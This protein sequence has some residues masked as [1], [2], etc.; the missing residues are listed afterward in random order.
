MM[1]TSKETC[2]ACC[3]DKVV[4]HSESILPLFHNRKC[5]ACDFTWLD[6]WTDKPVKRKFLSH[7]SELLHYI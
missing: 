5:D 3:S 7:Y 1:S 6:F 2:P 4:N